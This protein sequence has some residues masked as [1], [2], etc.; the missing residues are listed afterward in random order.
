VTKRDVKRAPVTGEKPLKGALEEQVKA[1]MPVRR[2]RM[3]R[4][5]I[6]GASV[7][8]TMAETAIDATTV[9]ANSR[10]TRP[11]KPS[12][13]SSGMKAPISDMLIDTTVKPISRAPLSAAF[14]GVSPSSRWR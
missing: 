8:D 10:K 12:I 9:M 6:M 5:A 11:M 3:K 14:N 2:A 4:A 1:T 13:M 7:S